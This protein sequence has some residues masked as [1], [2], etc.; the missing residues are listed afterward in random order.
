MH[1]TRP[2][3]WTQ[4]DTLKAISPNPSG[5]GLGQT[6]S[7]LLATILRTRHNSVKRTS[8]LNKSRSQFCGFRLQTTKVWISQEHRRIFL[9]S[10]KLLVMSNV[11]ISPVS[12]DCAFWLR[13][14][15]LAKPVDSRGYFIR[16]L[17]GFNFLRKIGF[18]KGHQ[19][20]IE[21]ACER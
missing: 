2:S 6:V 19:F 18:Q 17:L 14:E 12:H 15:G 9:I 4:I 8:A 21:I 10:P 7:A 11:E 3:A 1:R 13:L 16:P 20:L 5:L